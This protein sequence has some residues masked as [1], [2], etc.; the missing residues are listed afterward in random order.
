MRRTATARVYVTGENLWTY[1]PLYKTADN[2]DI[3]N[4][5]SQSDRVLT[6]GTHG[7]GYNYPMLKSFVL[8]MTVTF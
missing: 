1:S 3:E 4:I 2:V 7:E 5:T 8:G 6:T